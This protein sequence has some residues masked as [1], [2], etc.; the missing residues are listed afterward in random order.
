MPQKRFDIKIRRVWFVAA[1]AGLVTV[2]GGAQAQIDDHQY[3][4]TAIQA[5]YRLYSHQCQLCHGQ[6]G[7]GIAGVNL[8]RQRFKRAS[9]DDDIRATISTGV[10]AAGMPAFRFQ[11]DDLNN[12]V[13]FIRS[14]FDTSGTPFKL[15][16]AARGR[17]I[18]EGKGGC[19][20]CHLPKGEGRFNAPSLAE[21]GAT[22]QPAEIQRYLLTPTMAMLPIN[23]PAVIT[24]RDGKTLNGRRINEDT[25]SIQLRDQ[26]HRLH[27]IA[28]AD[29]KTYTL[30]RT[31]AMPS[32]AGKLTSDELADLT[33]YLMSLK[34]T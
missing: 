2:A 14:G 32:V 7:D 26:D 28:K 13:A 21:V 17:A 15:G 27:S 31:S 25:Y 24:L 12:L 8:A 5:G 23:R 16:D 18:Y 1:V 34:G 11:S 10:A 20:A 4:A 33:A 6:K 3:S 30:A 22:L 19:P 9:S 29:I